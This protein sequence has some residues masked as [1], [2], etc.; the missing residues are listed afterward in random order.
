MLKTLRIATPP[1]GARKVWVVIIVGGVA[2]LSVFG[3]R[4]FAAVEIAL[5]GIV[6]ISIL[7]F[8]IIGTFGLGSH[9]PIGPALPSI[10]FEMATLSGLLGLAV[11]TFVGL[12]YSCP[13]AE[14]L[15]DP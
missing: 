9:D 3:I 13:L 12:E 8:G 6:A 15:D 5:T 1:A 2:I 4:P 14:E 11:F 10:H 7:A